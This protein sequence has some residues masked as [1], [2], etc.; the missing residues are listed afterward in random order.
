MR[1]EATGGCEGA[2]AT[3]HHCD[4]RKD[5]ERLTAERDE[6]NGLLWHAVMGVVMHAEHAR[7]VER[8]ARQNAT[9]RDEARAEV[10]RLKARKV[11]R[12]RQ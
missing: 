6:L 7:I 9:E 10:A 11:N 3:M 8:Y 1:L 5:V 4:C 12:K 2:R